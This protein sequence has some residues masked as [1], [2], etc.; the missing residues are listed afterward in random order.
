MYV[1]VSVAQEGETGWTLSDYEEGGQE[2]SRWWAGGKVRAL[3]GPSSPPPWFTACLAPICCNPNTQSCT[4]KEPMSILK[5]VTN[6]TFSVVR[7]YIYDWVQDP[8]S[9]LIRSKYPYFVIHQERS[10]S[11]YFAYGMLQKDCCRWKWAVGADLLQSKDFCLM[12]HYKQVVQDGQHDQMP[13]AN[14]CT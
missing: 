3:E 4:I 7:I 9:H 10:F 8:R 11:F 5:I 12:L 6:I 13:G 14:C 1:H 2:G